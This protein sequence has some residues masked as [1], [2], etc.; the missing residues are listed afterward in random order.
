MQEE[1][2][3]RQCHMSAPAYTAREYKS[4]AVEA[5][6]N[7]HS[8]KTQQQDPWKA[9]EGAARAL[10]GRGRSKA[11]GGRTPALARDST[12]VTRALICTPTASRARLHEDIMAASPHAPLAPCA[13]PPK[14][15]EPARTSANK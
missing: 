13:S 2:A 7:P 15:P 14:S 4:V 10:A 5:Q 8:S 3:W 9:G 11:G 12:M 6:H 1:A